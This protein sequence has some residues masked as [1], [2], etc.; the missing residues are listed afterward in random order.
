MTFIHSMV[1]LNGL[2]TTETAAADAAGNIDW[3]SDNYQVAL[4]KLYHA[5][6]PLCGRTWDEIADVRAAE[7]WEQINAYDT[8][9]LSIYECLLKGRQL[10]TESEPH[11]LRIS[12]LVNREKNSIIAFRP[13]IRFAFGK[14]TSLGALRERFR[15]NLVAARLVRLLDFRT[16]VADGHGV[17]S[18]QIVYRDLRNRHLKWACNGFDIDATVIRKDGTSEVVSYIVGSGLDPFVDQEGHKRDPL[19]KAQDILIDP[20]YG[21]ECEWEESGARVFV[22]R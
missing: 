22:K 16:E 9:Y 5:F 3:K 6:Q 7:G 20:E 14:A 10:A 19:F 11:E 1:A 13:M 8:E 2:G 4:W 12:V 21:P 15:D 17:A 18:L